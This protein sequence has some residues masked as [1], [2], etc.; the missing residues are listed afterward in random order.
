LLV[1][2]VDNERGADGV[3]VPGS[4]H[5]QTMAFDRGVEVYGAGLRRRATAPRWRSRYK[6]RPS[7]M[8][9]RAGAVRG[10]RRRSGNRRPSTDLRRLLRLIDRLLP[11]RPCLT[12]LLV[13]RWPARQWLPVRSGFGRPRVAGR[14]WRG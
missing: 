10:A 9:H 4:Q 11:R 13:T 1:A 5:R 7:S 12:R 3:V 14:R 6:A 8:A 2:A